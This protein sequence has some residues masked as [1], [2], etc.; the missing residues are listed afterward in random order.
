LNAKLKLGFVDGTLKALPAE[1]ASLE[2]CMKKCNDMVLSRIFNSLI[3]DT[4]DS[5]FF[6]TLRTKFGKIFKIASLKAMDHKFFRLRET[7]LVW[8]KIKWDWFLE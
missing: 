4:V 5:G 3:H 8:L 6:M 2:E 7:F 1:E